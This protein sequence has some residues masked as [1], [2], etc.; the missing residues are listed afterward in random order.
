MARSAT[1]RAAAGPVPA[2]YGALLGLGAIAWVAWGAG[3]SAGGFLGPW[4]LMMAAMM[5]PSAAPLVALYGLSSGRWRLAL[6]VAGY[7]AVWVVAG[8]PVW[9]VGQP[10][11]NRAVLA[12]IL[13]AAAVYE[14]TP[15]KRACLR[16]C[17]NPVS[18]LMQR[19]RGGA[20]GA[21]RMGAQH[22]VHCLGC[23]WALM[24]VVV[25]AAGMSLAWAAVISAVIAV[26]KLLPNGQR[27]AW[28]SGAAL[29]IAA[30]VVA[31]TGVGV[32]GPGAQMRM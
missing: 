15:L 32:P 13:A 29:L 19:W 24:I 11:M 2:A 1:L 16:R 20:L 14:W 17:Q 5:L 3:L 30:L 8:L 6:L 9:A 7:L 10:R 22:G 12:G 26:Q 18:F 4:T 28:A 25:I 21:L 27:W 31:A 23:C